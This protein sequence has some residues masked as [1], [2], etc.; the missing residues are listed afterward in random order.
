MLNLDNTAIQHLRSS[1]E[2]ALS[3][4]CLQPIHTIPEPHT[5]F[6][7]MKRN[8]VVTEK[9]SQDKN[10]GKYSDTIHLILQKYSVVKGT[11]VYS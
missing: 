8:T 6:R 5:Q 7:R 4:L 3:R 2:H 11:D 10:E 1:I 9:P